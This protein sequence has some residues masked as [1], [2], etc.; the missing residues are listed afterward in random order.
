MILSHSADVLFLESRAGPTS[1]GPHCAN[2]LFFEPLFKRAEHM[3][4][5]QDVLPVFTPAHYAAIDAAVTRLDNR[6]TRLD[7][8]ITTL[9]LDLTAQIIASEVQI[10]GEVRAL[11]RRVKESLHSM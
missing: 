5:I 8:R 4:G 3:N 11:D 1:G 9:D 10:M 2:L 7:N 6:I